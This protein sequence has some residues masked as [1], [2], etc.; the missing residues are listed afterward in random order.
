MSQAVP[1]TPK[2]NLFGNITDTM[3]LGGASLVVLLAIALFLNPI[4]T[5]YEPTI[6]V[7]LAL[8]HF[9]NGPHF[10]QSYMI[11]YN[12]YR[13]KIAAGNLPM[14]LRLRYIAFGIIVPIILGAY[15]VYFALNPSAELLVF[16]I[17]AMAFFVGWHYVKQG[18]GMMILDTVLKKSFLTALE[19][20]I[21]LVNAYVCWLSSYAFIN[22]APQFSTTMFGLNYQRLM[23]PQPEMAQNIATFAMLV[24]T[25]PTLVIL[26]EKIVS[27]KSKAPYCG[28]VAYIT[29]IYIWL[30]VAQMN[31]LFLLVIP[32][33][34]SLQ[35]L[36][37]VSRFVLNREKENQETANQA[38]SSFFFF[39][40]T[41][42]QNGLIK[43]YFISVILGFAGFWG[44]SYLF[45][46]SYQAPAGL[47]GVDVFVIA[48]T[49]FI[50]IH[51]YFLDNVMWRKENNSVKKYLFQAK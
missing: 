19:K 34:H 1:A 40:T 37:V 48:T 28:I 21:L 9:I 3:L 4:Q 27:L 5:Y 32:A 43:F 50:N 8:S 11:F 45:L 25:L 2:T 24:T 51:H 16:S 20:K 44:L 41:P 7:V 15:F 39:K 29:S 49:I 38:P 26:A 22:S 47:E 12:G 10:A 35:Y 17:C 6:I 36:T 18:Y 14:P 42:A 23:L 13:E 30:F 31:P 33:F 46:P